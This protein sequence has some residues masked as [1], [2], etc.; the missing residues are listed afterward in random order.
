MRREAKKAQEDST[1]DTFPSGSSVFS[2][3]TNS[4][5]KHGIE[6]HPSGGPALIRIA[7]SQLV[8][9]ALHLHRIPVLPIARAFHPR[10]PLHRD[11]N[12]HPIPPVMNGP[13]QLTPSSTDLSHY[14][15]LYTRGFDHSHLGRTGCGLRRRG[16]LGAIPDL[17]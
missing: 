14:S 3:T 7:E 17:Q 16:E 10:P 2:P 15:V 6:A 1:R 13:V 5:L 9:Y 11:S 12:S 4:D 8:A